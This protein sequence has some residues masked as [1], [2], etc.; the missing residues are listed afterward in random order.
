MYCFPMSL[1]NMNK[2]SF[3]PTKD[4]EANRLK[5]GILQLPDRCHL[6]LDETALQP[7]Q[8][9]VNGRSAR[10][11]AILQ[12]LWFVDHSKSQCRKNVPKPWLITC[13]IHLYNRLTGYLSA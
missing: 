6:V 7:G 5:S 9:D 3:T 12:C 13:K 2:M 10:K 4:Y 1:D 8:L 11:Y